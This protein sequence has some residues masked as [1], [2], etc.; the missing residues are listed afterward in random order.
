MIISITPQFDKGSGTPLYTQLY[1]YIR[2]SIES[3]KLPSGAK[4]P[5]IRSLAQHL[6]L[7]K[8][9]VEAAYSQLLAEGYVD[10][11]E[12]G[13]YLIQPIEQLWGATAGKI[14]KSACL[15]IVGSNEQVAP[16]SHH[17]PSPDYVFRYGDIAFDRFPLDLW[18]SC[19]AGA[20]NETAPDSPYDI[21]GYGD[22]LGHLGLR[23]ELADYVYQARGITCSAD[24]I[25]ITAGTQYAISLLLQVMDLRQ[26]PFAM[27]E[28]GY[29]GVRAVLQN[30]DCLIKNIPV[31][32]DGIDI[33]MLEESDAAIAYVTPSHQFPLGMV[34]SIEKRLRLLQWAAA[35]AALVIEDDY[36]SEFRYGSRPIPSLKALDGDDRVIYLGTLSKA[37]LPSVRLSYVIMPRSFIPLMQDKLASYSCS[38][39]PLIQQAVWIF[40]KQGHYGRHIR[41][42]KRV[43]HARYKALIDSI[44]L[45]MGDQV[46][47]VGDSSGMHI[48]LRVPG[49][50]S[51]ELIHL[52][53]LNGCLLFPAIK[54]WNE[55]DEAARQYLML[56]FGAM[57]EKRIV[58]GVRKL[59]ET[60]FPA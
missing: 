47:I 43:Y 53:Q 25:F 36:D 14:T 38:V 18:K 26:L 7:S 16:N 41:R 23:E 55:P 21:L 29:H 45:L 57:D 37:F 33:N 27:E 2:E 46:H 15:P 17:Y 19:L 56:G 30:M 49:R 11:R 9:T 8:N 50:S 58:E 22:R 34:M 44:Q 10:S 5:A 52:A 39:S 3:G 4:L 24:Q 54:H 59:A 60:W 48:L 20:I 40:M 6:A 32:A 1:R 28:P 12:R 51:E 42:M 13:G 31:A 35:H